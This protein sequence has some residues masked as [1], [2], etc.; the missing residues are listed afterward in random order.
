MPIYEYEC[1]NCGNIEE[2]WQKISDAPLQ[3]CNQCQGKLHKIVSQSSFHL[4]GSGWYVTDYSNKK[5]ADSSTTKD[6]SDD[7]KT[8]TTQKTADTKTA[9]KST[10]D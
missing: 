1:E 8:D 9:A 2:A 5:S 4:K 7:K 10:S 6:S 3:A